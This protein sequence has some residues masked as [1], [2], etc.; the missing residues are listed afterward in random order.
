[1]R[2][3]ERRIIGNILNSNF[4]KQSNYTILKLDF[5]LS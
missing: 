2:K 5:K 1:M 3:N 4:Y